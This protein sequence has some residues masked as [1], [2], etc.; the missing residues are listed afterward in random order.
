VDVRGKGV[1]GLVREDLMVNMTSFNVWWLC[2]F[3]SR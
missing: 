2:G 3:G 1:V